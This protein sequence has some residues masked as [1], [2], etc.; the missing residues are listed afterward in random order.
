MTLFPQSGLNCPDHLTKKNPTRRTSNNSSGIRASCA[1]FGERDEKPS[2]TNLTCLAD[3]DTQ[4]DTSKIPSSVSFIFKE[5]KRVF[6]LI[7]YDEQPTIKYSVRLDENLRI[8]VSVDIVDIIEKELA[9]VLV[10][11]E[12]TLQT[13]E[14]LYNIVNNL[15]ENHNRL[16]LYDSIINHVQKL[17]ESLH[18]ESAPKLDFI[19]EQLHLI[20]MK[21]KARRY[22][23]S[24]LAMAAMWH[25]ISHATYNQ[26]LLDGVLTLPSPRHIRRLTQSLNTNLELVE[27][28]VRYLGARKSKLSA[29][30]L[31][32]VVLSNLAYMIKRSFIRLNDKSCDN[33]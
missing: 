27:S 8:A 33:F 25:D 20:T 10:P 18:D 24:L 7:S 3:F 15:H 31:K 19:L 9:A 11:P 30:D 2:P 28:S 16:K 1:E 6:L 21:P 14:Q 32:V 13:C 22:L 17:F 5:S 29:K 4:L 23:K 12:R 26:M